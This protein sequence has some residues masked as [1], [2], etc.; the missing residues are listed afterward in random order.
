[1]V[2]IRIAGQIIVRRHNHLLINPLRVIGVNRLFNPH[3]LVPMLPV[4]LRQSIPRGAVPDNALPVYRVPQTAPL[5]PP[6]T[7]LAIMVLLVVYVVGTAHRRNSRRIH[8]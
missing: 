4:R 6:T 3:M 1:M 5:D 7:I 8:L 2:F